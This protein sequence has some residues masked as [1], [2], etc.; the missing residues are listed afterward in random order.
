MRKKALWVVGFVLS[1][2]LIYSAAQAAEVI[3]LKFASYFPPM[4]QHSV[5]MDEFTKR[6]NKE[7]AG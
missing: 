1:V 3:K 4:H 6:L 7:L 5:I 2:F